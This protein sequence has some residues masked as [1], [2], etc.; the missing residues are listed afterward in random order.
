[1]DLKQSKISANL[2]QKILYDW[3]QTDCDYLKDKTIHQLFEEQVQKT[4]DNIA[5]VFQNQTITYKELNEKANQLAFYIRATYKNINNAE[6]CDDTLIALLLDRSVDM[7]VAILAVLKSGAAYVPISPEFPKQRIDYILKDT[8]SQ[9][10]ISQSDL[11]DKLNK[12]DTYLNII[13]A[14]KEH[15]EYSTAN[16]NVEVSPKNLAYVIYTSGTTGKPKGVM[17]EHLA[18]A[19]FIYLFSRKI[20]NVTDL[21]VLS[22]TN[23]VFDIFGLEYALPLIHGNKVI[24]SSPDKVTLQEI[25]QCQIIQQ[26]PKIIYSLCNAY[27]N[28]FKDKILLFGGEKASIK[29][30]QSFINNFK[31]IYNVYGPAETVIWSC[32]KQVISIEDFCNIGKPLFNEKVYILNK[33]LKLV[34]IG[35]QG[36]LYIGGAGLA[37][38]YLNLPKLT[39]ERFIDNPFATKTDKRL[40]YTKLYKTGDLCKWLNNGEI[41]YIDRNDFQVKIRGFRVELGEIE[42]VISKIK[43]IQQVCVITKQRI[44]NNQEQTV[45]IAYYIAI[46]NSIN[47]EVIKSYIKTKLPDYMLPNF[48]VRLD[49]FP[50]NINGKLDRK[51]LPEHQ[52]NSTTKFIAPYTDE[53]KLIAKVFQNALDIESI[54]INDNIFELGCDSVLA[55]QISSNISKKLNKHFNVADIFRLKTIKNIT[56]NISEKFEL[57]KELTFSNKADKENI[58]FIHPAFSGCEVYQNLANKLSEKYNCIGV[59]NYNL[60][61]TNKIDSLSHLSKLYIKKLKLRSQNTKKKIVLSGWSLG[62]LIAFE[63]AYWLEQYGFYNIQ[64]ILFDPHIPIGKI[65]KH[66]AHFNP[67]KGGKNIEEYIQELVKDLN[68]N[69]AQNIIKNKDIDL[70]LGKTNPSGKLKKSKVFLFKALNQPGYFIK[71]NNLKKYAKYLNICKIE[72]NHTQLMF[73]ILLN[74]DR[75][76]D[77]FFTQKFYLLEMQ[78]DEL[79]HFIFKFKKTIS[80]N[81]KLVLSISMSIVMFCL[82]AFDF[83]IDSLVLLG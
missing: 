65:S 36:E 50:L 28:L 78:Q 83:I 71:D 13:Y 8:Q 38:G 5:L 31:E 18:F 49:K 61:K 69:Y 72:T 29:E 82:D 80:Y 11:K 81:K 44:I 32:I 34:S 58:Y 6:L 19:S 54:G 17:I 42:K 47:D 55:I 40:G 63:M 10:L 24:I 66:H 56:D 51:A 39:Q 23:I 68:H 77:T 27:P 59:D 75:Y 60:Y 73:N 30:V 70:T 43:G 12:L 37:R 20:N 46:N 16:P 21:N 67:E 79:I 14:D 64:L 33:D 26:T 3:N 15:L 52:Y 57:V 22:L 76:K 35:V 25:N 74:W 62:G 2:Y 45:L 48:F 41:E 9:I 1:M 53:Q 4:P 7:I